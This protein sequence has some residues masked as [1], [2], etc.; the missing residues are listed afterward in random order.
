MGFL[1]AQLARRSADPKAIEFVIKRV[2][3]LPSDVMDIW[4]GHQGR[5]ESLDDHVAKFIRA[6]CPPVVV[7]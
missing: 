1:D 5:L 4:V 3:F 7:H 2:P 6:S